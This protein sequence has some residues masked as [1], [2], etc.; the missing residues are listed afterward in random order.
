MLFDG[1]LPNKAVDGMQQK[2]VRSVRTANTKQTASVGNVEEVTPGNW[3][4]GAEACLSM[5]E[6][7]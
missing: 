7:V 4:V 5:Y 6:H 1:M 2:P 3:A